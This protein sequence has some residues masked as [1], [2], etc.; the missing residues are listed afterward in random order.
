MRS[1][2]PDSPHVWREAW[3]QAALTYLGTRVPMFF[4]ALVVHRRSGSLPSPDVGFYHGGAPHPW[5][6]IDAFQRWDAYWFLNV[7]REGYH[8]AAAPGIGGPETNVTPFPVYPAAMAVG[9]LLGLDLAVAGFC[10]AQLAT[11]AGLVVLHRLLRE[12]HGKAGA[13]LGV[14]LFAAVP[15]AFAFAAIYSDALYFLICVA[16]VWAARR[17]RWVLAGTLGFVGSATRIPGALLVV[18]VALEAVASR[19]RGEHPAWWALLL[20]PAGVVAYFAY[21]Y[22]L[23]GEPLA[24]F[25]ASRQGWSKSPVGPWFHPLRWFGGGVTVDD[26]LDIVVVAGVVL[27]LVLGF[28]DERRS[29][30]W[31]TLSTFLLLLSST[32]LD[33]LPR[34]VSSLFPLYSIAARRLEPHP[35]VAQAVVLMSGMASLCMLWVWMTWRHSF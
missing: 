7:A 8:Y 34:Y 21:L 28:R 6:L 32:D 29:Q 4:F 2:D 19:R 17:Q 9:G 3:Q 15:W 10:I 33:G 27:L 16:T 25:A 22:A 1:H 14:W 5:P 31:F 13:D 24:Y 20:I 23:T 35:Q 11:L 18:P 30:W 26:R 12:D